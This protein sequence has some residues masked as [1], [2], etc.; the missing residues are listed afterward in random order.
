MGNAVVKMTRIGA[1]G[2]L[3]ACGKFEM[4]P[5]RF[6]KVAWEIRIGVEGDSRKTRNGAGKT[7]NGGVGESDRSRRR[8]AGDSKWSLR[9]SEKWRGR[10]GS[11]PKETRGRLEMEPVRLGK[12]AGEGPM[13]FE[14]K[15]IDMKVAASVLEKLGNS[16]ENEIVSLRK[17]I[18]KN[19]DIFLRSG[20]GVK[21]IYEY[22]KTNGLDVGTYY[23]FKSLYYRVKRRINSTNPSA[24]KIAPAPI[25]K[26]PCPVEIEAKMAEKK[27]A[28]ASKKSKEVQKPWESKYNPALPLVYLPG[29]VEAIIDPETGAKYFEIKSGKSGKES[30]RT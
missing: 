2:D 11:E 5:V 12:V 29:G 3:G 22:L 25:K 1:A 26:E 18:E 27:E 4:E 13:F 14:E 30:E 16:A 10:L 20:R 6:G 8:L 21:A 7:Q 19:F 17:F 9:D 23:G 15:K 28:E 24:E